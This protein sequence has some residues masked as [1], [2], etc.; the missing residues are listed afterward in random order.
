MKKLKKQLIRDWGK[1][2]KDYSS[3]CC[4]CIVWRAFE[5]LEGVYD[6]RKHLTDWKKVGIKRK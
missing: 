6:E 2:C 3:L 4:V 1:K 5:D